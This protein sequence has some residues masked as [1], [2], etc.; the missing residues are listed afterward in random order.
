MNLIYFICNFLI[1][2]I[3]LLLI[4]LNSFKEF[5]P[6]IYIGYLAILL[7]IYQFFAMILTY[8]DVIKK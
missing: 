7:I 5:I 4:V 1:Q 3:L 6:N 2:C 8:Y